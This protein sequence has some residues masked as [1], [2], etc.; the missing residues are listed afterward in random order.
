MPNDV[1]RTSRISFNVPIGLLRA[2]G[3]NAHAWVFQSFLDEIA[4]GVGRD[5]IEFQLE[6]LAS[7]LPGEGA[8][9]GG[10]SFGPGFDRA[11]L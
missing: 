7:S 10:N 1:L 5:P 8:G 11:T 9:K 6:L 3:D 2:P 4:H